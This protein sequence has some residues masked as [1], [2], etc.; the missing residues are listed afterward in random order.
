MEGIAMSAIAGVAK[1]AGAKVRTGTRPTTRV[2]PSTKRTL[3][4]ALALLAFAVLIPAS[5]APSAEHYYSVARTD[6][7]PGAE[8]PVS[9]PAAPQMSEREA[10][11]AYEKLPLSFI[12]NEGQS[13]N[14]A[15]RYYAR[16]A[17]Y[18]F[19]FTKEGATLS[20]AEGKGHGGHALA[21]DFL[22]A[23]PD[24]TLEAHKRLAGEVNYLGRG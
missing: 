12:P 5:Q 8:A 18:G 15:V 7:Q 23:D 11:D 17:G 13:P 9:Q 4:V 3:V 14:E 6:Y 16:G 2:F 19:Y 1:A 24:A 10:L 22:G 21:L 20:F